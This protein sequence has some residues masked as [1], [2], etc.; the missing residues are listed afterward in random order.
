M[1]QQRYVV[2]MKKYVP[3]STYRETV[4]EC[5][6]TPLQ[7]D[8][9]VNI[10]SQSG[11]MSGNIKYWTSVLTEDQAA[12]MVEC[13]LTLIRG[14]VAKP[15]QD[16]STL[17]KMG[18]RDK[19]LIAAWNRAPP[20]PVK[21]CMQQPFEAWA[22]SHPMD[23]AVCA[24]DGDLT[25]SRLN[26]LSTRLA[27]HLADL[28]VR[29]GG[30]THVLVCMERSLWTP[31][32]LLAVLKAGGVFIPLDPKLPPKRVEEI[33]SRAQATI[34]LADRK[35][36]PQIAASVQTVL[37]LSEEAL[38]WLPAED[39]A[40]MSAA[41][42]PTDAAYVIFT[43]G[44]TGRPKGVV[45]EHQAASSSIMAH[46][47][48]LG[49]G[50][51]TRALHFASLSFD[52]CLAEIFTTLANGGCICIPSEEQRL[53]NL[54]EAITH[55]RVN[56]A[57]FTPSVISLIQPDQVSSLKTLALGGEP[58]TQDNIKTWM[59]RLKLINVYGPTETCVYCASNPVGGV[60]IQS[61]SDNIGTAIGTTAWVVSL[62][63]AHQLAAVGSVGELWIEGPQLA[64][65]YLGD[66]DATA[67]AFVTDPPFLQQT[68]SQS[69]LGRRAYRTGDL[70]RYNED[71]SLRFIG[72]RDGQVKVRGQRVELLEIEHQ[73]LADHN[74]GT[75]VILLPKQGALREKVTAV[76]SLAKLHDDDN[77]DDDA[78]H[79][80]DDKDVSLL[81]VEK[82]GKGAAVAVKKDGGLTL[83]KGTHQAVAQL[84]AMKTRRVLAELLPS[85][86]VP[87]AWLAVE[88][89]PLTSSGKLDRSQ[90]TQ[91]VVN[92]AED[93][94][95]AGLIGLGGGNDDDDDPS[96]CA[97][98]GPAAKAVTPMEN[99]L[100]QMC[101]EVLCLPAAH[102]SMARSFLNHGGDSI[103]AM[104]LSSLCRERGMRVRVQD[105]L[106]NHALSQ[107]AMH[108]SDDDDSRV[109]RDE[110]LD[111]PFGLSPIQQLYFSLGNGSIQPQFNQ[112][113]LVR[114]A[115][116]HEVLDIARAAEALAS[117]HSMLRARFSTN[118]QGGWQQTISSDIQGS[119]EFSVYNVPRAQASS[120]MS[121]VIAKTKASINPKDG[122]VFSMVLFELGGAAAAGP[123]SE[124]HPAEAETQLLFLVAHCLVID[125][126]SWRIVLGQLEELLETG[127]LTA[128][129]P[130]PFQI[131]EKLQREYAAIELAPEVALPF[132]SPPPP[133]NVGFWGLEGC[134]EE[135]KDK[136]VMSF[137]LDSDVTDL[138]LSAC[139]EALNTEPVDLFTAALIYSFQQTFP[140]R[141]VPT[142]F[143][144]GHGREPWDA[145]IDLSGT[146]G[147]FTT[148]H[149][150][151][152]RADGIEDSLLDTVRQAKDSRRR[153][154]SNGW[155]YFASRFLSPSGRKAFQSNGPVEVMLNYT[156]DSSEPQ[157]E[158]ANLLLQP[159]DDILGCSFTNQTDLVSMASHLAVFDIT[160]A[161]SSGA[162]Q[163]TWSSPRRSESISGRI[164]EWRQSYE[165][166]LIELSQSLTKRSREYTISDMPLM[167][168]TTTELGELVDDRLAR[169]EADVDDIEDIY[170]CTPVQDE[171]LLCQQKVPDCYGV[172][173]ML[174]ISEEGKPAIQ[175]L[176]RIE[177]VWG[178]LIQRHS[179][180]RTV[181]VPTVRGNDGEHDQVLFR[182]PNM[183]F[184]RLYFVDTSAMHTHDQQHPVEYLLFKPVAYFRSY[185]LDNGEVY[186][187]MDISHAVFDAWSGPNLVAELLA[188][189]GGADHPSPS[190]PFSDHVALLL[191]KRR[192]LAR[193]HWRKYLEDLEPSF[194]PQTGSGDR[195]SRKTFRVPVD[196]TSDAELKSL[197]ERDGF[198]P[199]QFIHTAWAMVVGWTLGSDSV[200]FGYLSHGRQ[201]ASQ[202]LAG[203]IGGYFNILACVAQ[204]DDASTFRSVLDAVRANNL[205]NAD[206]QDMPQRD[207]AQNLGIQ[208]P[209][210]NTLLNFAKFPA[211]IEGE[212]P[213]LNLQTIS[214]HAPAEVSYLYFQRRRNYHRIL[215]PCRS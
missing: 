144:E 168:L 142:I 88:S 151:V 153:T 203:A 149:P 110:V 184:E 13:F 50:R 111:R 12:R 177:W 57:F 114:L 16:V 139:N 7:Y 89:I 127:K 185:M 24:W 109:P 115:R 213:K 8:I 155:A 141:E 146:V 3:N 36:G 140:E 69:Q 180:L 145:E 9:T 113:L 134:Q 38:S 129:R 166:A 193:H 1:I 130:V 152:I 82:L 28:G 172:S 79:E 208:W 176:Q 29:P 117:Q 19:A 148:I 162:L 161:V 120:R 206:L 173:S 137:E 160:V 195:N 85:Y 190:P 47:K 4:L 25:Y 196:F 194:L 207:A 42:Q 93:M 131:W 178:Q 56:W 175:V 48:V 26:E 68:S 200:C 81:D 118:E 112:S 138:L 59:N 164:R 64:R 98:E 55:Y 95:R 45:M 197:C 157:L 61:R 71:G 174:K 80:D 107:L 67:A 21:E 108:I 83:L 10:S 70:V 122:P 165:R 106:R 2:R 128:Q 66:E 202:Q 205:A 116:R 32:A 100:Q 147:C 181:F 126:A 51:S 150:V 53:T 23:E 72:R 78:G 119:F 65:C 41:A 102:I 37:Q 76:I 54:V 163:C 169:L 14:A 135:L 103:T 60:E 125:K 87:T 105:I 62:N 211:A 187:R 183:I 156:N 101:A 49:F 33:A 199:Q 212:P 6:L 43:S 99:A 75:G 121:S 40:P 123:E 124:K 97:A 35:T 167:Q 171:V 18:R 30:G 46:G 192:K 86:M 204:W 215:G 209:P 52:A 92:M 74:V 198:T 91:W 154:P 191:G 39:G 15:D 90:V 170:P 31:V 210:F 44:S 188:L 189:Y 27:R 201:A 63:N 214:G 104:Q 186:I 22:T 136:D 133:A 96:F 73:L 159:E 5:M 158:E 34:G 58:L 11:I 94:A 84:R 179:S 20:E 132:V 77:N 182:D 143:C 17:E